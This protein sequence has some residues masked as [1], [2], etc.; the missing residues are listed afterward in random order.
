MTKLTSKFEQMLYQILWLNK[1]NLIRVCKF[2]WSSLS[3]E[4]L[5]EKKNHELKFYITSVSMYNIDKI[6]QVINECI[7][8]KDEKM[9]SWLL[10][11]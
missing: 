3:F 4:E 6:E 1:S 2:I 7:N 11:N 8:I 10:K 9:M 5:Q